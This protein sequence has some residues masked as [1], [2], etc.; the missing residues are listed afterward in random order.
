MHTTNEDHERTLN[1]ENCNGGVRRDLRA[2]AWKVHQRAGAVEKAFVLTLTSL[3][4]H[5]EK[6]AEVNSSIPGAGAWSSYILS[7]ISIFSMSRNGGVI[8]LFKA[9]DD[10][11]QDTAWSCKTNNSSLLHG[12]Y[13]TF[14]K[15]IPSWLRRCWFVRQKQALCYLCSCWTC[16]C[17]SQSCEQVCQGK[18]CSSSPGV[19]TSRQIWSKHHEDG[20]N[21]MMWTGLL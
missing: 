2:C 7:V 18:H 9:S 10:R 21:L 14:K 17:F 4:G 20:S 6:T 12:C 15:W 8:V 1:E 16:L 3:L 11:L 13:L 19:F 5:E